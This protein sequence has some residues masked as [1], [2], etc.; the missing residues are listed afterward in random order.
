LSPKQYLN[1][2][3]PGLAARITCIIQGIPGVVPGESGW[4]ARGWN[5]IPWGRFG[6]HASGLGGFLPSTWAST[7]EAGRS[8]WDPYAQID[9]MAWMLQVGRGREFNGVATGHC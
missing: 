4:N 9:A 1:A 3:Y 6:E 5:P 8:I 2:T 7:P